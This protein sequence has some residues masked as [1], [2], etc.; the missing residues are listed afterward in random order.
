MLDMLAFLEE[1]PMVFRYAWFTGRRD[2]FPKINLLNAS[3]QLTPLGEAYINAP[4]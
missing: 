1:H 2:D 4:Y 3:G